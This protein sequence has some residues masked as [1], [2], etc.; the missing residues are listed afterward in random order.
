MHFRLFPGPGLTTLDLACYS[1]PSSSSYQR[2]SKPFV[3]LRDEKVS[4]LRGGPAITALRVGKLV[5]RH[6]S[7][8]QTRKSLPPLLVYTDPLRRA[9]DFHQ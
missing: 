9:P 3:V 5:R 2:D 6:L 7:S 1:R 8:R 4:M